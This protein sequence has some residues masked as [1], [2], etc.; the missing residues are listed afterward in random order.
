MLDASLSSLSKVVPTLT[1]FIINTVLPA[2]TIEATTASS[3]TTT[4][5]IRLIANALSLPA[6]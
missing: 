5:R 3:R 2:Y 4:T 6:L 1:M